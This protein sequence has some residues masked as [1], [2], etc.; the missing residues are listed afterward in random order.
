[1]NITK[2]ISNIFM[3]FLL[4]AAML[5]SSCGVE[6]VGEKGTPL[7]D[8]EY[9][10][11][12]TASVDGMTSRTAG[13][14]AWTDGDVIGVRI[15]DSEP[16]EYK[17]DADGGVKEFVTPLYWQ[18]TA[19]ATVTAWYPYEPQT[20]VNISYQ[21]EGYKAFD[22]LYASADNQ[23]YLSPTAL[24]FKHQMAKVKYTLVAG[25]GITDE[26]LEEVNVSLLGDA[27]ASYSEG[28]LSAA[29][30]SNNWIFS[31]YDRITRSGEALLVPQDMT[32]KKFI[33]VEFMSHFGSFSYTPENQD[34]GLL[35]AGMVNTYTITINSD[36]IDVVA[37]SGGEWTNSGSSE[38]IDVED[39]YIAYKSTDVKPGDYF[40]S[41]GTWSDGGLRKIKLDGTYEIENKEPLSNKTCVGI[42][43]HIRNAD[44]PT[45]VCCYKTFKGDPIGY[46]VS[47]DQKESKWCTNA[48]ES[49]D[50]RQEIG[51]NGYS[52]TILYSDKHSDKGLVAIPWCTGH[53]TISENEKVVFSSW[54]MPSQEEYR[55]MRGVT[56]NNKNPIIEVLQN[57]LGKSSGA[58]FVDNHYFS[59]ELMGFG[60]NYLWMYNVLT[61]SDKTEDFKN[62]YDAT[63]PYRA[64]CTFKLIK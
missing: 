49:N 38:G 4:P 24:K 26:D 27:T 63:F 32:G 22:F 57:N 58:K 36:G 19:S 34:A 7:P 62:A 41:D 31:K 60:G 44:S 48:P 43:F 28:V 30:Q 37:V 55:Q 61:G 35:K 39:Y 5:M 50:Y 14:D 46:I 6:N 12:L 54:Y 59:S 47:I 17:L 3:P 51:I 45:D 15:G 33:M 16:G 8:G 25:D 11:Q 53:A 64:V 42:V 40:Y 56:I 20:D 21:R 23:S 52:L 10:L 2:Q 1:M 9:P 18:N 13:K 29:D